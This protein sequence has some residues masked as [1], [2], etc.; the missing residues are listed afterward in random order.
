MEGHVSSCHGTIK[1]NILVLS[2]YYPPDIG[3]GALRA[4]SIVD[5]LINKGPSDLKIDVLTTMPNRYHSLSIPA[6]Q[7]EVN[8]KISIN[9]FTLPKHK[10]RILDQSKA[11]FLFS[12]Y[13]QKFIFKKKWDIVVATSGRLMTA[14][15]AT[16]VAKQT[17]AKLYLDI[18]DLFTDTMNNILKKNPLRII[19]PIFSLL[20]KWCFHSAD[21]LNIVST[22]FL[23]YVKK[24]APDLSPSV[25]TNGVDDI[26]LKNNFSNNQTKKNP[27]V[28]YVGNIGDGQGLEK[29]IPQAANDLKDIDFKLIGDGS[30]RQILKK[31]NLFN[32]FNNIKILNPVLRKEL[33][34]E[35]READIL[36][37]HLNDLES[38]NKVLPSK[39]FEY[40]ATGKPILA[41]VKGYAAKF[42][43]DNVKGV[44]IFNPG[45]HL[46][47]KVGLQKLLNGPKIIDRSDFCEDYSRS[48]IIEKLS[49]DI[50]SLM[51]IKN[52]LIPLK[53]LITH[54]YYWPD[55]T[56]CSN[57]LHGI[58]KHLSKS[59]KVDVL[60]SQPSYGYG[61]FFPRLS[62]LEFFGN[63]SI[64]RL[65]L[66]NETNSSIKRL[67]NGV[68]LGIWILLKCLIKKYDIII[69]TTTP[70]IISAFCATIIKKLIKTK[71]LYYGMDINPEIGKKVSNDFKN[72]KL[73]KL[74]SKMDDWSCKNANLIFT[75]SLDML[76]TLKKRSSG[77][78][79]NLKIIN[80][81]PPETLKDD[82]DIKINSSTEL[83]KKLRIIYTG[84]IGRFQDLQV[85]IDGMKLVLHR[86]D[87]EL[88]IVGD[89]IRKK[90]FIEK[91]KNLS[92]IKFFDYQPIEVIK[93]MIDNSDIGLVTLDEEMYNYSYPSKI[94]TYLQQ[95]KPIIC[96][97]ENNSEIVKQMNSLGYGFAVEDKYSVE[98]LLIRLAD[99]DQWKH[100]MKL[101]AINAYDKY[102]SSK[103]ILN[104]WSEAVNHLSL[105][106]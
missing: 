31:S 3:P 100:K 80:N 29:I 96:S 15:L 32:A 78:K 25:Y 40:A 61:K 22:G 42:L 48:R 106:K 105:T 103:V 43:R 57:I 69:V 13:V 5:A 2:Y 76:K 18:R 62:S 73:Y 10:N 58:A 33:I 16:L 77:K 83:K 34:K 97:I 9:R 91:A 93:N 92:N 37:L 59:H 104:Q 79:Y 70:P 23:D 95:G 50:L 81:F 21:K 98:K 63:L 44:E 12:L 36:F 35:Y 39:I 19:M 4:K 102:F 20:E 88:L 8:N 41:G 52:K 24:V 27:Q 68:Y 30:A 26:F 86:K 72:L 1:M 87:I 101:N 47:M 85:I 7:Y 64:R 54:R 51:T 94:G 6:L 46:A 53:I 66:S 84:N 67:I 28:L 45:D 38:F 71:I 11:F 55:K 74:L 65:S 49:N 60:T 89:G 75:N 17:S 56:P 90:Y 82:K 14:S 99:N